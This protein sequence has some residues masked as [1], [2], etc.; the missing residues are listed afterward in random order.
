MKDFLGWNDA[1]ARH[2]FRPENAGRTVFLYVTHDVIAEIG[3]GEGVPGFVA[4]M[5][6]GPPWKTRTGLCQMALQAMRGWRNKGLF[7]PPYIGYLALFVLALDVPGFHPNAYYAR[8]RTLL[9]EEPVNGQYNSFEQMLELWDDLEQWANGDMAGTLG[10]VRTDFAGAWLHVGVP[11]AQAIL[12]ADEREHLHEIFAEEGLDP[13]YPPTDAELRATVLASGHGRLLNRTIKAL[14]EGKGDYSAVLLERIAAELEVWDGT[15]IVSDEGGSAP[16]G[17]AFL[18]IRVD[19]IAKRASVSL[20]CRFG[21]QILRTVTLILH[22]QELTCEEAGAF[23]KPLRH[24][25]E[26]FDAA[27]LDWAKSATL[28]SSEGTLTVRFPG[29]DHRIFISGRERGISG[30]VETA[31]IDPT[32]PFLIVAAGSLADRINTWGATSA[33]GFRERELTGGREG[34]RFFSGDRA[35]D[36]AGISDAA[37]RLRFE[38]QARRIRVSGGIRIPGKNSYFWFAPPKVRLDAPTADAVEVNGIAAVAEED[39]SFRVPEELLSERLITVTCGKLKTRIFL[40]DGGELPEWQERSYLADGSVLLGAHP[41]RVP[42]TPPPEDAKFEPVLP[43]VGRGR[44]TDVI[45]R[46]PGEIAAYEG[47]VVPFAAVWLLVHHGRDDI[48]PYYVAATIVE[49]GTA[50]APKKALRAW[51]DALWYSRMRVTPPKFKPLRD[52]WGKYRDAAR[53]V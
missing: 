51:K 44:R 17:Q 4:S 22:G 24:G 40:E 46:F 38:R 29:C 28:R 36:D 33:I 26:P 50:K 37:A 14:E 41:D 3:Q 5:R 42:V 21:G 39:G 11:A 25:G 18:C 43:V 12:R 48:R 7:Y 32:R 47:G 19:E 9:G 27:K 52:L 15:A 34:W 31:R 10:I 8:L 45:G 2:F 53:H 49:P 35:L 20:R 30:W 1:I 16:R 6:S 23:S 13:E